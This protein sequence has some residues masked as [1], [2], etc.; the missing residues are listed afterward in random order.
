V[1]WRT[2]LPLPAFVLNPITT[3]IVAVVRIDL[4]CGHL[5]KLFGGDVQWTHLFKLHHCQFAVSARGGSAMQSAL[6]AAGN[7]NEC[8]NRH[9]LGN[10]GS[11]RLARNRF[12]YSAL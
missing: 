3:L 11:R 2:A 6:M 1:K 4:S 12:P 5:A 9:P 10:R 8:E 7:D